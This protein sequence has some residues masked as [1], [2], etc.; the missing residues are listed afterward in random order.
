[1]SNDESPNVEPYECRT[2][3]EVQH[4]SDD[5]CRS[6]RI[7]YRQVGPAVRRLHVRRENIDMVVLQPEV[8]E[9]HEQADKHE[10]Y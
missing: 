6:H 4:D 9:H 2:H 1:M 7:G 10:D 3:Y 5:S 8:K